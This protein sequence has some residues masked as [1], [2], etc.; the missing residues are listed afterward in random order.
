M[1]ATPGP[2]GFGHWDSH[3]DAR[4]VMGDDGAALVVDTSGTYND[5]ENAAFIAAA[6][7]TA[8]LALLDRLE[9]AEALHRDL[10]R[11][12]GFGDNI[13]EPMADNDTIVR[14][15][16]EQGCEAS[17][18]RE[19]QLWRNDCYEAGHPTDED[20]WEHDPRLRLEAAEAAVERVEALADDHHERAGNLFRVAE[21]KRAKGED[22]TGTL[23]AAMSYDGTAKRLRAALDG[24][25]GGGDLRASQAPDDREHAGGADRPGECA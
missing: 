25:G 8:V 13:T 11:R 17:E 18:W 22:A 1:A 2:W 20:C 7:P 21:Q 24:P 9:A 4:M 16:D 6:N 3:T 14:W 15:F 5:Y 23:G 19:S 12:L 10:T